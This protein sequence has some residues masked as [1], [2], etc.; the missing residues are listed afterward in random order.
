MGFDRLNPA[1]QHHVVNALGW[2]R[3]RPLQEQAIDP[4]MDGENAILLAPTAGGKTEAAIF[5]IFSRMLDE[6]WQG[7]SVLYVCP[8]KAL[9]NNLN[10][11]LGFFAGLLGRRVELWHG[12]VGESFRKRMRAE[13]PDVLLTTPESLEAIL[14]ST[15]SD[16][17]GFFRTVRSVVIDE[18]HAFAG[19]D[20]GWH[21][22]GVLS[23]IEHLA[24]CP[25]Q[26][27]GLSATVGNPDDLL[28]WLSPGGRPG[29]VLAPTAEP[30][31]EEVKVNLDYVGSLSNAAQVISQLHRGRKRLVFCDSRSRVEQLAL[32]LRER[33]VKTFVS[34]S[35]LGVQER[36]DAERAFTEEQDCVIVATSTLELGIDVGDLDHV[37]QID[38][39]GTVASFLQRIGRTGRRQGTSRNCLFLATSQDALLRAAALI[40]LWE[41]GFIE[42][43]CP[44]AKPFHILAQQIMG[45]AL[46]E[47]GITKQNWIAP[48]AAFV[49]QA[50]L[51]SEDGVTIID[52]ML[53]RGLFHDDQGVIWFGPEGEKAF[54][55]RHFMELLAVFTSDPMM[56]VRHG[57]TDVG[58][59][60]PLT[61]L[62]ETGRLPISLGGRAWA[63]LDVDWGRKIIS[64]APAEGRARARW[65][66]DAAPL[67]FELCQEYQRVLADSEPGASW[68]S[69]ARSAMEE[70]RDEFDFVRAGAT[71]LVT[72]PTGETV[73]WTFAGLLAN[74]Q[75]AGWLRQRFGVSGRPENLCVRLEGELDSK[76]LRTEL[77]E[78]AGSVAFEFEPP[79]QL[80]D[81]LKF[82]ECLPTRME[83]DLLEARYSAATDVI[84]ILE[85]PLRVVMQSEAGK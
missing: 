5:P 15:K 58:F 48:L 72:S 54:G 56:T 37:I 59:V 77:R 34:H 39:P 35:S 11:R 55:R 84:R 40:R 24:G 61:V 47:R 69:R 10:E 9:L 32:L 31:T 76:R 3:L 63:V 29:R 20:R 12:D 82:K 74:T 80:S 45:L 18:I 23:R 64:V 21:L 73:W 75:V 4:L 8:I 38:A 53:E 62:G 68:S 83:R 50:G 30:T 57:R 46:Q 52:E 6:G 22:L 13:P 60:S 66:G 43:V 2:S 49:G 28:G 14:V 79:D 26:R 17:P 51:K 25:L 16:A 78:M 33:R 70:A 81:R 36:R 7:L 41:R 27:V 1:I 67:S 19:D 65:M 42:P 71:V 85:A 44:P